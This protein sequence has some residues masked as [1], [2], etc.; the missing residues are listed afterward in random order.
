VKLLVVGL[1]TFDQMTGGSARYMS[2]MIAALVKQGHDVEVLTAGQFVQ[3]GGPMSPGAAG[4]VTRLVRRLALLH[5]R[6]AAAVFRRRPDVVNVHFAYDGIGAVVGA[7][8]TGTPVVVMFQ[9]PWAR[10]AEA[11]GLRGRWPLSTKARRFLERRVYRSAAACI[12]LSSAFQDLL[13]QDYGVARS[14]I[15]V[16]PPGIDLSS[17]DVS[18]DRHAARRILGLADRPTLVTVRRLVRRMGIDLL[19]NA[20]ALLPA[21]GRPQLAIA[22]IGPDRDELQQLAAALGVADDVVF[23]GRVAD[24]DLPVLYRAGDLC[25][26]PTRELEGYGYVVLESYASGTP[27]LATSVGGLLDVVGGF[28][29][30][31]LVA[32]DAEAIAA[33]IRAAMAHPANLP[34]MAACLA[35]AARFDWSRVASDV[36]AVFRRVGTPG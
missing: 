28:D 17:F 29:P 24:A 14:R 31:R 12:V 30:E 13:A 7:R 11:T 23:L 10:E 4:Q 21:A 36:E 20:L 1:A 2:G 33:G 22:G 19:I 16:I 26:V 8:L 35:Y 18:V 27:V 15:H 32:P 5:P 6:A 25:V 9:G 3:T 34:D